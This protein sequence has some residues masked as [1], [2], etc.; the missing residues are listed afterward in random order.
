MSFA[1]DTS[2]KRLRGDVKAAAHEDAARVSWAGWATVAI[3][4][5]SAIA[6]RAPLASILL[7][8]MSGTST[9]ELRQHSSVKVVDKINA[10][11]PDAP[12]YTFEVSRIRIEL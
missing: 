10:L 4:A 3:L 8:I 6:G 9:P 11:G 7:E 1:V 5:L 12:Y 2:W